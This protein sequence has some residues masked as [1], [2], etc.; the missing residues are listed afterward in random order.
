MNRHDRRRA[1]LAAI[2]TVVAL[3]A[4]WLFNRDEAGTSGAP[5]IGTVGIEGPA[6]N[7]ASDAPTTSYAPEPPVFLDGNGAVVQPG[8]VDIAIPPAPTDRQATGK[9]SFL[10][11]ANGVTRPCTTLLAPEATLLTIVNVDN[12]QSTTCTNVLGV[13]LPAGVDIVLDTELFVGISDL[14]DAPI[15][16]RISW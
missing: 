12:G 11:Y 3:P 6:A 14:A 16:V 2:L 13:T 5:K 9:A 10:R 8:V 1:T 4:I 15:P 7:G